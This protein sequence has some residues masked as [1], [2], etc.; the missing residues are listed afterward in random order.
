MVTQ[1][2]PFRLEIVEPMKELRIIVEE[3]ETD[4]T[5]ELT[6]KARAGALAELRRRIIEE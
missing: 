5:A 3:N 2:G 6:W 4:L 1:M